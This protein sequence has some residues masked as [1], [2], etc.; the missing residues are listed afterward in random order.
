MNKYENPALPC[1]NRCAPRAYYLPYPDAE[2]AVKRDRAKNPQYELLNGTWD[3]HYYPSPLDLPEKASGI[4]YTDTIPVPSCF[5]CYGYGQINY[6]NLDY[7]H[8]FDP[9]FVPALNG[10]GVY[11]RD[12]SAKED[13]LTYLVFEGAGSYIEVYVNDTYVGMTK[14]SHLQAEFDLTPFITAGKNRLTVFCYTWSDGSYLECQDFFRFHGIFRDVYL[15]RRKPGH[16]RDIFIHTDISGGVSV[17][18]T[19]EMPVTY[20][21]FS[22]DGTPLPGANVEEPL[23]WTAETPNLYG[24]LLKI[25]DEY[26]YK[27]IGFREIGFSDARELLINGVAVKLKG[28]NRHD[29]HPDYGWCTPYDD[30]V[31]DLVIMK[32]NNINCIR[33]SHYPNAPEFIELCDE[34]GFYVV[35]EGDSESHGAEN[36]YGL[37]ALA[38]G[39]AIADNPDWLPTFCDRQDRLVERDKN[40][41]S[42]IFW[43]LGNEGQFGENFRKIA[44]RTKERD[45]SRPVHYERTAWPNKAYDENQM[46]I[47]PCVDV[48]SRMYTD[49][50]CLEIQGKATNDSR[51]YFLSEYAHASGLGPGELENYWKL[52]YR[53]PALIGGCVWEWCDHGVT[54]RKGDT[55]V[56][57]KYGGDYGDFPN[58]GYY[59]VD[60]LVFPD[61]K[62]STGLKD[63]K[64]VIAPIRVECRDAA[65]GDFTL[66]N[67]SD[68]TDASYYRAVCRL[69][70]D[71]T[72][73][74]ELPLS[75]SLA[76]HEKT[77]LHVDLPEAPFRSLLAVEFSFTMPEKTPWCDAGHEVAYERFPVAVRDDE[78]IK[79]TVSVRSGE[80]R[81]YVTVEADRTVYTFDKARGTV[82]SVVCDGKELLSAPW[83]VLMYRPIQTRHEVIQKRLWQTDYYQIAAFQP[84]GCRVTTVDNA[85]TVQ[86]T[87]KVS[88]SARL[89]FFSATLTYTVMAD[90]LHVDLDAHRMKLLDK[91][92]MLEDG[93]LDPNV[94]PEMNCIPRFG[95]RLPLI[96][97]FESLRYFGMGPDECYGDLKA[98]AHPGVYASS[99]TDEYVPYVVPQECGNHLD[100]HWVSLSDGN[101]EVLVRTTGSPFCFSA[102]HHSV[103]QIDRT[104]HDY[105]MTDLPETHLIV[106]YKTTGAG[107]GDP[108][109]RLYDNDVAL[110][111]DFL[112]K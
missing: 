97:A 86:F 45:P 42:V 80:T 110:Q 34:Y 59:C 74:S 58:N 13:E 71:D 67:R 54:V 79:P 6:T 75:L 70:A 61:R 49:L 50:R 41:P 88:A 16:V 35:N 2:S 47:D 81:R 12:F 68:F 66:I 102:M 23:L 89:P 10:V 8:P 11:A 32:K 95:I 25:G 43:S 7:P 26:I 103:E 106:D 44:Y 98:H 64:H 85:V 30:M 56:G 53:Y 1:E 24:I 15:L 20:T 92:R 83:N 28:V 69:I 22:P 57:Y 5:E 112:V 96:G 73:V 93:S 9:P 63:Y 3:F 40:A 51:P 107:W 29:S 17:E 109:Y 14:G 111:F 105:E 4:A 38:S 18:V 78:P 82:S 99:V 52:I 65:K 48:I 62:E 36:A 91:A 100:T 60:G 87:G 77:E 101:N 46:A 19:P 33:T 108:A 76:P 90:G 104:M 31:R 37:C 72:V 94:K 55:V 21:L 84:S 39:K 27:K